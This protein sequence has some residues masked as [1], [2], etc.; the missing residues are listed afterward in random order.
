MLTFIRRRV[1]ILVIQ[2]TKGDKMK[3]LFISAERSNLLDSKNIQRTESLSNI[4]EGLTLAG[5]TVTPVR[6]MYKGAQERSFRVTAPD[7]ELFNLSMIRGLA[8]RLDQESILWVDV[9]GASFL[10]YFDGTMQHL[11]TMGTVGSTIGLDAYSIINGEIF[12]VK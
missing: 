6:G 10:D 2:P 1:T 11:G 8:Q 5:F 12:T 4:L 9:N 7:G 3:H